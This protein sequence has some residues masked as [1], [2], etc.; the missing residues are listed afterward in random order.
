MPGDPIF[1]KPPVSSVFWIEARRFM[2][3][4]ALPNAALRLAF[5]G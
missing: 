1:S 2:A 4:F 3:L 5:G